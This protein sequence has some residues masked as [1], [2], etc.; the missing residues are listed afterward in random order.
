MVGKVALFKIIFVIICFAVAGVAFVLFFNQWPIENTTLAL[1]W[2][3]LWHGIHDWQ[4]HNGSTPDFLNP[5]W[6]APL[7]V[8]LRW[9][10]MRSGW[11]LLAFFTTAVLIA[12]VPQRKRLYGL[13]IILLVLSFPSLR[14]G[15]D[16]NFE[17]LIIGGTVLIGYA[18]RERSPYVLAAG[19]LLATAKPQEVMLLIAALGLYMLLDLPR[20]VILKTL[21]GVAL[22]VI[23]PCSCSEA[24]GCIPC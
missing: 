13:S 24:T 10:S 8:P 16:G 1:D 21:V 19:I 2:N 7:I 4:L 14:H 6:I 17:G 12:S 3:R 5:P 15:A 20:P 18:Y 9:L 23:P 22:V 11:G